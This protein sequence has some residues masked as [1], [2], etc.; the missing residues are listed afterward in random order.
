MATISVVTVAGTLQPY[1]IMQFLMLILNIF[2]C[3]TRLMR[4]ALVNF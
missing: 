2:K 3:P 4:R 1:S